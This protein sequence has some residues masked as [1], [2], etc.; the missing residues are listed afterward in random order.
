ML[1]VIRNKHDFL[2]V[3]FLLGV[4]ECGLFPGIVYYLSQCESSLRVDVYAR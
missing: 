4:S 1:G 3:R 2:G